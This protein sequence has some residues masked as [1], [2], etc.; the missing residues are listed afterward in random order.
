MGSIFQTWIVGRIERGVSALGSCQC[1]EGVFEEIRSA[2]ITGF[3]QERPVA[4]AD[5]PRHAVDFRA[6]PQSAN[7]EVADDGAGGLAAG[8]VSLRTPL[9]KP[10]TAR[11][12][13]APPYR[14]LLR[15]F[16]LRPALRQVDPS[17]K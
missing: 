1:S 15:D 5:R 14:R 10:S 4:K 17:N 13:P 16:R 8:D 6:D 2:E 12:V 9:H 11:A 3:Q 7:A